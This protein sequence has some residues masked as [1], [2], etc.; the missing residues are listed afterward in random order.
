MTKITA[1]P[2]IPKPK[3]NSIEREYAYMLTEAANDRMIVGWI[4]EPM[5]LKLAEKTTYTPDFL[6]VHEDR[7]QIVEVKARGKAKIV[8]SPTTGK[9]YKKQWTS[10]REDAIV[11]VK[12]AATMFPWFEWTYAYKEADGSWTSEP[13]FKE[14]NTE[15]NDQD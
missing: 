11:K 2:I 7:F 9:K 8:T 5:A 10:K 13:V 6:V 4:F 3:M 14:K 12:V 15:E 1:K